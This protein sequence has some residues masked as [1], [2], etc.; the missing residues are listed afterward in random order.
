MSDMKNTQDG[1]NSKL[2]NIAKDQLKDS[3]REIIQSGIDKLI[4]KLVWNY[5][6]SEYLWKASQIEREYG[7]L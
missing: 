6:D 4:L 1:N 5:K 2:G 7:H 3:D